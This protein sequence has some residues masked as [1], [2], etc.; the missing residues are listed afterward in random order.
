[1]AVVAVLRWSCDTTDV[2]AVRAALDDPGVH[3]EAEH[4]AIRQIGWLEASN[5]SGS[6]V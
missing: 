1:M 4:P 6:P 5:G 2:E 3:C